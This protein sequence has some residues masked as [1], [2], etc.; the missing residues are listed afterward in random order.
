MKLFLLTLIYG[1]FVG[2]CLSSILFYA[3][4][5]LFV[6]CCFCNPASGLILHWA[7][8]R[9]NIKVTVSCREKR[10]YCKA[11]KHGNR[12]QS[13]DLFL[14]WLLSRIFIVGTRWGQGKG[15]IGK[16]VKEW[17]KNLCRHNC[18]SS[19][20]MASMKFGTR[21]FPCVTCGGFLA[22]DV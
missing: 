14:H 18:L 12:R 1:L 20:F 17:F 6:C 2:L 8:E 15:M 10:I 16:S 5:V 13:S 7:A 11:V 4:F 9:P 3:S 21:D 19:V 22:H